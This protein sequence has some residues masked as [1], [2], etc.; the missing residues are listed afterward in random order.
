M[1]Q[2]T[3]RQAREG[4]S[5]RSFNVAPVTTP[6]QL[7]A[8]ARLTPSLVL[9]E[10]NDWFDGEMWSEMT[11][12]ER[13]GGGLVFCAGSVLASHVLETDDNFSRFLHNVL[14]QMG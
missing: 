14:S 10:D 6:V 7:L 4:G 9:D 1:A 13:E 11:I 8:R 12:Q 3:T 2:P 5:G